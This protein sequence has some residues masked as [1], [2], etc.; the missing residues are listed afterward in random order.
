LLDEKILRDKP[1]IYFEVEILKINLQQKNN[2]RKN[3]D[4]KHLKL[5][6]NQILIGNLKKQ[7]IRLNLKSVI[8]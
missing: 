5:E 4:I 3:I 2:Y 6:K 7:T 1:I 8:F